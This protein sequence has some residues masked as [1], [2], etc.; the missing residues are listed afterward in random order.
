MVGVAGPVILRELPSR[1]YSCMTQKNSSPRRIGA[2]LCV[3]MTCGEFF[4]ETIMQIM[5]HLHEPA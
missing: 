2:I 1:A 5:H 4:R 3:A